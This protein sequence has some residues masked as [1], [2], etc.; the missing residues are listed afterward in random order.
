MLYGIYNLPTWLFGVLTIAVFAIASCGGLVLMR[1]W[2]RNHLRLSNDT[3]E[4]VN[5]YFAGV[6]VIYGLL[7]GLVAVAT[8]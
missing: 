7:L 4:A 5:G 2:I 3:N 6:G 8:W 1:G